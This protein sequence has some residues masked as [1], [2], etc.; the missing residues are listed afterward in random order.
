MQSAH[1]LARRALPSTVHLPLCV[2]FLLPSQ[3]IHQS[4]VHC[5]CVAR[6]QGFKF[7]TYA[8]W[9]IRQAVTRSISDQARVV[10]L[11]VHLHEAMGRVSARGGRRLGAAGARALAGRR[12]VTVCRPQRTGCRCARLPSPTLLLLPRC[13]CAAPSSSCLRRWAACLPR[14]RWPTV[15]GS[16][17]PSSCRLVVGGLLTACLG[18]CAGGTRGG[19]ACRAGALAH[20]SGRRDDGSVPLHSCS[21]STHTHTRT[22]TLLQ[23]SP[24]PPRAQLYKAFRPPTSRDGGAAGAPESDE[25]GMGEQWVEETLEEVRGGAGGAHAAAGARV[26]AGQLAREAAGLARRSQAAP[27]LLAWP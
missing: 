26:S 13:R 12:G 4:P 1:S 7:S 11:P 9:W 3:L 17:T 15:W 2:H 22:H 27:H 25:K 23:L 6:L 14:R 16:P 5:P 8:H 21:A 10:R 24:L 18:G 19:S 20:Q